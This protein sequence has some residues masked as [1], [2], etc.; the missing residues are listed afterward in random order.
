MPQINIYDTQNTP[1][2][3]RDE[4]MSNVTVGDADELHNACIV[5]CDFI[6]GQQRE[7]AELKTSVATLKQIAAVKP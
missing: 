1:R 3:L 4:L 6:I 7:I 5:L 2:T